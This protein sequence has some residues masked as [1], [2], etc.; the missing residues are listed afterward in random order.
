M[1]HYVN[2]RR[3]KGWKLK[4]YKDLLLEEVTL[5][6]IVNHRLGVH[7]TVVINEALSFHRRISEFMSGLARYK[8]MI[9]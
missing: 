1:F 8:I 4:E 5:N 3:L 6:K 9:N 7:W 2:M